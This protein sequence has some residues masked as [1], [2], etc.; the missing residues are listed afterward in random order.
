M[1]LRRTGSTS[2]SEST[3]DALPGIYAQFEHRQSGCIVGQSKVGCK[4]TLGQGV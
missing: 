4:I 1:D 3:L 2:N